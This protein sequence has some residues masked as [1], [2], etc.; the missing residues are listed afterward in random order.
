MRKWHVSCRDGTKQN[1]AVS[2]TYGF[3]RFFLPQ[4]A[5]FSMT[6]NMGFCNNSDK[7][8]KS[9]VRRVNRNNVFL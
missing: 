1:K 7:R 2:I 4:S 3:Q 9:T 5:I 6:V 8:G